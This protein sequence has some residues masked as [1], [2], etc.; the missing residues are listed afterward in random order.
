MFTQSASSS[1]QISCWAA[2]VWESP[3]RIDSSALFGAVLS[4]RFPLIGSISSDPCSPSS[5]ATAEWLLQAARLVCAAGI[6]TAHWLERGAQPISGRS[7]FSFV[8]LILQGRTGQTAL[9]GARRRRNMIGSFKMEFGSL[10]GNSLFASYFAS[11]CNTLIGFLFRYPVK[12]KKKCWV[13][14]R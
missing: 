2:P 5:L 12:K 4:P 7:V 3:P 8:A 6:T 11:I 14:R 10:K 9:H 13:W 1:R